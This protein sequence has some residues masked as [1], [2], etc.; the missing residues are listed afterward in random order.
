MGYTTYSVGN[1]FFRKKSKKLSLSVKQNAYFAPYIGMRKKRELVA[2]A[3][4]HVTSRTNNKIRVFENN[5]GRKIMLITL[6]DAKDK[7]NFRLTNFCVMPTHI[8]LLIKPEINTKLNI[9][10]QWIKTISAKRW[11]FIH[12]SIDHIWGER[13]FSREIKGNEEYQAIM[14]YIDRNPVVAGLAA[15][16]EEWK[17]SAA[18][19]KKHG[20]PSLVDLSPTDSLKEYLFLPPI[21]FSV[22]RFI[23]P[24]QLDHIIHYIGLYAVALDRL[25]DLLPKIPNINDTDKLLESPIYLHYHTKTHDYFIIGYDGDDTLY[26]KV[27]SKVF[28]NEN[29]YQK[30]NLFDLMRN[31]S[32]KLEI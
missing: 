24:S 15:S 22:S 3:F 12:G 8:H 26:G 25:Y 1:S 17:A 13:Y 10:I 28:P 32:L 4:Y 18:F 23:P 9:I 20:I 16:P 2:G 21:P 5:L 7:F 31:P 19:Y 27:R 6:Q 11:N 30:I 14:E 29:N